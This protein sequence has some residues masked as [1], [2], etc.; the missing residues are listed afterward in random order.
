MSMES[1]RLYGAAADILTSFGS[2]TARYRH[3]KE[4]II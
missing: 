3:G 4:Y 1:I 2:N